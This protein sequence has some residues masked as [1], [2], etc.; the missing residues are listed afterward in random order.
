VSIRK[1]LSSSSE[2]DL[3][4]E[5]EYK[6]RKL[7]VLC[8]FYGIFLGAL[9][10][11]EAHVG[12]QETVASWWRTRLTKT[13]RQKFYQRAVMTALVSPD[14]SFMREELLIF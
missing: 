8:L 2:V 10:D 14:Q 3:T 6:A 13:D 9:D 1:F 4:N 5:Q 7:S 11:L 12:P